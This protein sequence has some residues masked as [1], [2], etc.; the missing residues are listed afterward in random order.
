[1][2]E[3]DVEPA[4]VEDPG[5]VFALAARYLEVEAAAEEA[6][7]RLTALTGELRA[8]AEVDLPQAMAAAG[9]EDFRLTD[10][11][12]V[13]VGTIYVASV[14]S[15]KGTKDPAERAALL[16][17]RDAWLAWLREHGHDDIVKRLVS[18]QFGRGE[19]NAAGDLAGYAREHYPKNKVTDEEGVHSGTLR[20]FV[21]EQSARGVQFPEELG[22]KVLRVA[23]VEGARPRRD[24]DEIE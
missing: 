20:A 24:E 16:A 10:G 2:T 22:V 5:R 9:V 1:M 19:G 11:R 14:P 23:A 21:R 6:R 18:V 3:I 12:R 17:R 13:S 8:L 15:G 4:P 7:A